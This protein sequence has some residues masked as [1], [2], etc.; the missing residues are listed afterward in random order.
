MDHKTFCAP[1][2]FKGLSGIPNPNTIS[3]NFETSGRGGHSPSIFLILLNRLQPYGWLRPCPRTTSTGQRSLLAPPPWKCSW[4]GP[5]RA[6]KPGLPDFRGSGIGSGFCPGPGARLR[7]TMGRLGPCSRQ[8]QLS[9]RACARSALGWGQKESTS[10]VAWLAGALRC[11]EPSGGTWRTRV[12]AARLR[13]WEW[14]RS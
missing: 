8:C 7:P 1:P 13:P 10:F 6:S 14:A 11:G 12:V 4:L 9:L 5:I 3:P 2:P